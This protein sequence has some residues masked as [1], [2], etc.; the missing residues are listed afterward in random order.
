MAHAVL[1]PMVR[2]LDQFLDLARGGGAF[3]RQAAHFCGHHRETLAGLAG[4][5]R[6]HRRVQRQDIGLEGNAIDD[7]DDLADARGA[8]HDALHRPHRVVDHFAAA[9][10]HVGCLAGHL[11]GAVGIGSGLLHRGRELF[12]AGRGFLQR[13]R[14]VLG[15]GREVGVAI[16]DLGG[17]GQRAFDAVVNVAGDADQ[18]LA[19]YFQR[20]FQRADLVADAGRRQ[21]GAE[22]AGGDLAGEVGGGD[23]QAGDRARKAPAGGE[24]QDHARGQHGAGQGDLFGAHAVE[25]AVQRYAGRAQEQAGGQ[26]GPGQH[27][28]THPG[29]APQF[30]A[31]QYA[32]QAGG[33]DLAAA[34]L[35]A[36]R[37]AVAQAAVGGVGG[38]DLGAARF[39]PHRGITDG[40]AAFD[41]GRD[42]GQHPVIA[43]ILAAVLDH[44]GP[45]FAALDGVPEILEGGLG[46]VGVAHDVV[47]RAHQFLAR[48]AADLDERGIGVDDAAAGVGAR[49]QVLLVV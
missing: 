19:H 36:A 1:D 44:A 20:K 17:R 5:R 26:H 4:A 43:P 12:H 21:G 6:F 10:G 27:A 22:I 39:D 34:E 48:E 47:G 49:D 38:L 45:G 13:G 30:Q 31:G 7:A 16:G 2:G 35:E 18:A 14:L 32:A 33:L 41:D 42:V 40:L 9:P 37:A 29:Q 25:H 11:V 24:D 15:V 28:R 3:L 8:L 46:H 23:Q